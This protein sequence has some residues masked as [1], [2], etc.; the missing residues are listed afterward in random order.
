MKGSEEAGDDDED[1]FVSVIVPV[2]DDADRLRT[3]IEALE[4]QSYPRSR[5]E[6]IVVDNGSKPP[7][8]V[9]WLLS[10]QV[11]LLREDRPGSYAARNLGIANARGE[12]LAFTDSDCI[13]ARDWLETGVRQFITSAPCWVVAGRVDLFAADPSHP[14]LSER[15]DARVWM[16]Q[17]RYVSRGFGVTANLM[18]LAEVFAHVGVF[19]PELRSGGDWEWGRRASRCGVIPRYCGDVVVR[20]PA[21]PTLFG[22][23]RKA[24]RVVGGAIRIQQRNRYGVARLVRE[25]LA[26]ALA[27]PR[28]WRRVHA[29]EHFGLGAGAGMAV[30]IVLVQVAKAVERLRLYLGGE[31]RRR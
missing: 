28:Y 30:L 10:P 2:F 17:E 3:C 13:P 14:R 15:Y 31:C 4:G 18:V 25:L 23:L 22:V 29:G 7:I 24:A 8:T 20:H 26:D 6:V 11:R 5:Y 16:D 19:D 1:P 21:I 9:G 12:L 27:I